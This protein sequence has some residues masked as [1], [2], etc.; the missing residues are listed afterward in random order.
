MVMHS[1]TLDLAEYRV[2]PHVRVSQYDSGARGFKFYLKNNGE[3]YIIPNNVTVAF[4]GIK[5]DKH[6]FEYEC[7]V[8]NNVAYV[9]CYTQMTA[10]PGEVF[11]KVALSN[12][13][14]ETIATFRLILEVDPDPISEGAVIS[15]SDIAYARQLISEMESVGAFK[16]ALDNKLEFISYNAETETIDLDRTT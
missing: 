5:P 13:N 2:V 8:S 7:G 10:V 12:V 14:H 9:G 4:R 16:A 6:V 11:C 15:D 3:D 1:I